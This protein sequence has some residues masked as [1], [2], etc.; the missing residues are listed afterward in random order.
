MFAL[1]PLLGVTFSL[2][3]FIDFHV[4]VEY[5]LVLLNSIQVNYYVTQSK[6]IVVVM[7]AFRVNT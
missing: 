3:F 2:G 4:T 5:A 7:V 1:L 6:D